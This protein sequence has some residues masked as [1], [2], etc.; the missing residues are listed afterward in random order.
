[1]VAVLTRQCAAKPDRWSVGGAAHTATYRAQ[2]RIIGLV[3]PHLG[4][5]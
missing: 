3:L 2:L 5:R 1:M 4:P